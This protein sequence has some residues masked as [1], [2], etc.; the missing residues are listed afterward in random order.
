MSSITEP[1]SKCALLA[2]MRENAL[3]ANAEIDAMEAA[4]VD[5]FALRQAE[6]AYETATAALVGTIK[7]AEE[8]GLMQEL[9]DFLA[10][11]CGG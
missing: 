7:A 6:E 4:A 3:R 9:A 11:S 10:A 5:S 8:L 1:M 2:A